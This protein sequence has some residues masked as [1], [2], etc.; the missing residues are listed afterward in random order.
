MFRQKGGSYQLL[1]KHHAPHTMHT[2][3]ESQQVCF[4][5]LINQVN[6]FVCWCIS[7]KTVLNLKKGSWNQVENNKTEQRI[8]DRRL[9]M[10]S[11]VRMNWSQAAQMYDCKLF[12]SMLAQ[13]IRKLDQQLPHS[14]H[15][16]KPFFLSFFFL[17]LKTLYKHL[18]SHIFV[19]NQLIS[20]VSPILISIP[21]TNGHIFKCLD[22]YMFFQ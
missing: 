3:F 9:M 13:S 20:K 11:S 8:A 17:Q 6:V 22:H 21:V 15:C 7:P 16:T 19:P 2:H 1:S 4:L 5:T 18:K 12:W 14:F 10:K